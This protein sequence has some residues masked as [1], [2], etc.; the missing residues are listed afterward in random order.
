MSGPPFVHGLFQSIE[1][2]ARMRGP[3]HPPADD[4]AG[5]G[6]DDEGH[7]DAWETVRACPDEFVQWTNSRRTRPG[8]PAQVLT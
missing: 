4:A 2:E 1:N 6:V 7:V 8:R 3:A 5:I